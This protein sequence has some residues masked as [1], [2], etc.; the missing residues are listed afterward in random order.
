MVGAVEGMNPDFRIL[1]GEHTEIWYE[2]TVCGYV[3]FMGDR[4]KDRLKRYSTYPAGYTKGV[5]VC[6]LC[7]FE[8]TA[9]KRTGSKFLGE[10]I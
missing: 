8:K 3:H 9:L 2:F 6:V 1:V 7:L 4:V 10:R 5:Y